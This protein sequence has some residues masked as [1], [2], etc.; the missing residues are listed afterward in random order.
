MLHESHDRVDMSTCMKTTCTDDSLEN[1]VRSMHRRTSPHAS[2][3]N[4]D[5]CILLHLFDERRKIVVIKLNVLANFGFR[6]RSPRGG[7]ISS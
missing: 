4:D 2:V 7:M 6:T 1:E 5:R 3:T